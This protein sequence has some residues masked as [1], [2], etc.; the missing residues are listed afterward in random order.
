MLTEALAVTT[1]CI[2]S[3][4]APGSHGYT[5]IMVGNQRVLHHRAV[6][7]MHNGVTVEFLKG[8]VVMHACDNRRCVNPEHLVLGTYSD[9]LKDAQL[10]QRKMGFQEGHTHCQKLT[11]EIV[12]E[13]RESCKRT[14]YRQVAKKYGISESYVKKIAANKVWQHI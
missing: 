2:N 4:Y 11:A 3:I 13:I 1:P 10:K 5:M 14:V 12:A 9:N 8:K 7:A 6:Y